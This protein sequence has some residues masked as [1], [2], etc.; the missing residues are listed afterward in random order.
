MLRRYGGYE[1]EQRGTLNRRLKIIL[2]I[3]AVAYPVVSCGPM[4][5]TEGG[6]SG[7]IGTFVSL[8]LG[9]LLLVPWL[10]GLVVLGALVWITSPRRYS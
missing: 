9:G 8:T 2:A 10:L 6:I 1:P 3:W 7:A 4:A 5:L